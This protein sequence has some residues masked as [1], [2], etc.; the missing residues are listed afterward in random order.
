MARV[1]L[2]PPER[3]TFPL[4]ERLRI[5]RDLARLVSESFEGQRLVPPGR[6]GNAMILAVWVRAAGT[7]S[8]VLLLA[9][10]RGYEHSA[11]R[12]TLFGSSSHVIELDRAA[13]KLRRVLRPNGQLPPHAVLPV[14]YARALRRGVSRPDQR[15]DRD[16]ALATGFSD[17]A[18]H[19]R[20]A[21]FR[22]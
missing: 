6:I 8:A 1:Q 16:H 9:E 21:T 5:F 19:Q 10:H 3:R 20:P 11:M 18:R 17:R 22:R 2:V 13:A 15:A 7:F 4:T 14:P 12:G